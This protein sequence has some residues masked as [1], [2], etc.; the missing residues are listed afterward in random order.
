MDER[1]LEKALSSSAPHVDIPG[2]V[3]ER[4]RQLARAPKR[5]R[6]PWLV[7]VAALLVGVIA[8]PLVVSKRDDDAA[9]VGGADLNQDDTVNVLDAYLLSQA[10]GNEETAPEL[11]LNQDGRVDAA[12]VDHLLEQIVDVEAA[13]VW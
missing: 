2:E 9:P 13:A 5:S 1:D 7:L 10:I 6:R 8:L 3:D 11:D 4:M 12:D